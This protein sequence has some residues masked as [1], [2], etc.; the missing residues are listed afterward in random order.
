ML[1]FSDSDEPVYE[2]SGE[3]VDEEDIIDLSA[4]P[5]DKL[6]DKQKA[7]VG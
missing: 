3:E 2:R 5:F 4:I 1:Q 7:M 6:T